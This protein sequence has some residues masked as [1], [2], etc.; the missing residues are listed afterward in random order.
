MPDRI[1][2]DELL[3]SHRYVTLSSDTLRV[4]FVHLI[5][6]ADS[7][8]NAE[9]TTTALGA[10]MGRQVDEA[11]AAKWLSELADVD[12]VRTYQAAGKRYVHVPRF[13]QRLRYVNGKHPHPPA[14]IEC[15]EIK[16]LLAKVGP[17]S[18]PGQTKVGPQSAEVKRSE[19][20][21]SK[22]SAASARIAL[23]AEAGWVG[24][25][26]SD[27]ALWKA[28]YPAIDVE[29]QLASAEAWARANP[30]NRKSNWKRF[31]TNWMSR[32]QEKA[33]RVD[34]GADAVRNWE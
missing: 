17:Q 30:A 16:E 19:V 22:S 7:L 33:A 32:A 11:T 25:L 4:L 3:R 15:S 9:A 5:L 20:K 28:A 6:S 14:E 31:L 12:L 23:S 27:R 24:V 34:I 18:G 1:I 29:T 21:R 8:G 13:R 2:R 10:A 26:D